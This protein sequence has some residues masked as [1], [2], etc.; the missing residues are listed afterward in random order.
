[1][2][3]QPMSSDKIVVLQLYLA[4]LSTLRAGVFSSKAMEENA[5]WRIFFIH[6][7]KIYM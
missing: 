2:S 1:M 7:A 4:H 6:T 3:K 5:A